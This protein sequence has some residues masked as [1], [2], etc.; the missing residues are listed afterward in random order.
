[1]STGSI[2][3]IVLGAFGLGIAVWVFWGSGN[4]GI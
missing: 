3:A 4:D 2:V 1:M